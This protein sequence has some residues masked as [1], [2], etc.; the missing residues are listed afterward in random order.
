MLLRGLASCHSGGRLQAEGLLHREFQPT[1]KHL[2]RIMVF[3]EF[4]LD[5]RRKF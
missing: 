2:G 4:L 1:D 3:S 5:K